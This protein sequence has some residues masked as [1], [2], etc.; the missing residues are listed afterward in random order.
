MNPNDD[1]PLHAAVARREPRREPA[2]DPSR[3]Q[4]QAALDNVTETARAQLRGLDPELETA[5][6][7]LRKL[8]DDVLQAASTL[9]VAA[10]R[11]GRGELD[12]ALVPKLR[13]A[14][15][16]EARRQLVEAQRKV[17]EEV[18][19]ARER[20]ISAALPPLPRGDKAVETKAD[21]ERAFAAADGE[22]ASRFV[23]VCRRYL[24]EGDRDALR[25]LVSSWGADLY[26]THGGHADSFAKLRSGVVDE[27][28]SSP[29]FADNA[30]AARARKLRTKVVAEVTAGTA[31]QVLQAIDKLDQAGS[32]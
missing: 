9:Q 24:R 25:L 7:H 14:Y 23:A 19:A 17:N 28:F 26:R 5:V 22:P 6:D 4:A 1:N 10:D 27:A 31:T 21:V 11:A 18:E 8:R 30:A 13:A 15:R 16:E 12:P 3:E 2:R 32:R 29:A 20:A